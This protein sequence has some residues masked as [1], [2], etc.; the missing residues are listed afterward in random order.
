MPLKSATCGREL[1]AGLRRRPG[2]NNV[3]FDGKP[4]DGV[5]VMHSR[6]I[7]PNFNPEVGFVERTDSNETYG[8]LNFKVRRRLSGVREF[9]FE[10][11]ILHAPDTHNVAQ[12]QEWQGTFRAEFNNGGYTDDDIADVF[13][14]RITTPFHIYK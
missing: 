6:K 14:Q 10:G 11:F 7:G 12:T 3:T 4:L 8:D 2:S 13:T 1:E 5:F 9:Q